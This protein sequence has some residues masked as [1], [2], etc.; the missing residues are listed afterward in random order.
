MNKQLWGAISLSL[1]ASIWGSLYVI[2]KYV[3]D[4]VPPFTLLWLR[5]LI[6]G[7]VLFIVMILCRQHKVERRDLMLLAWIG[8]IGYFVS[9]GAQFVGTKLSDA[10][11]GALITT[12]SPVFT[13][14]MARPLLKETLDARKLAALF[15]S[16]LGIVMVIGFNPESEKSWQGSLFLLIAA[17]TWAFLSIYVKKASARYSTLTITTYAVLFAAVFTTPVAI[18]EMQLYEVRLFA[19]SL[20][21]LGTL[22]IGIVSTAIALFLWNK[23]MDLMDAGVGSLFMCFQPVVGSMLGWLWLN[24]NLTLSFV[25]GATLILAGLITVNWPRADQILNE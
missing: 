22:Y 9:I 19:S 17:I 13:V 2:S 11:T 24:E 12:S 1:A 15:L 6:A 23:G 25:A 18:G 4:Y 7:L 3:M 21:W 8:F 14:L 5:Y 20:V 16:M 10:H